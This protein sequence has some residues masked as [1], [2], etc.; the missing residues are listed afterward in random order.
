[1]NAKFLFALI[2]PVLSS[3]W[4]GAVLKRQFESALTFEYTEIV[5]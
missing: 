1:M 2:N 4:D 5:K 3:D